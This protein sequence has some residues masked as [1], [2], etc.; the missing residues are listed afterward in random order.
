MAVLVVVRGGFVV[1]VVLDVLAVD[2]VEEDVELDETSTGTSVTVVVVSTV[3]VVLALA[4]VLLDAFLSVPPHAPVTLT[5]ART[6]T[7]ARARF[8]ITI[9]PTPWL[10]WGR[11]PPPS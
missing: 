9:T 6:Q 10:C 1:E 2:D 8:A 4:A 5:T 3:D 7:A 11:G